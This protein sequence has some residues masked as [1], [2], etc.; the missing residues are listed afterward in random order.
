MKLN[1]KTILLTV[2]GV[3][4]VLAMAFRIDAAPE[5]ANESAADATPAETTPAEEATPAEEDRRVTLDEESGDTVGAFLPVHGCEH[6]EQVGHR[7]VAHE[8]FTT[9]EHVGVAALFG[10]SDEA[11][12]V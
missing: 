9:V 12:G 8:Y 10:T 5:D 3:A 11:V 1:A 7:A 2:A 4:A 6:Q